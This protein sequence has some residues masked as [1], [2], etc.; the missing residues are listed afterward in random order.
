MKKK[1]DEG[2]IPELGVVVEA[3]KMIRSSFLYEIPAK[4]ERK[5]IWAALREKVHNVLSRCHPKRRT[6]ARGRARPTFVMTTTYLN[7]FGG[8]FFFEKF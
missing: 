6:G 8:N 2:D 5:D 1:C 7:F 4:E 3:K